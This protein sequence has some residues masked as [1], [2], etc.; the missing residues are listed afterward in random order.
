METNFQANSEL[1]FF[2]LNL[3]WIYGCL[4]VLV[5]TECVYEISYD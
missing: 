5:S 4:S 3:S 2:P 1:Y